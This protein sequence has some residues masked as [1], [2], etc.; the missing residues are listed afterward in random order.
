[1][2]RHAPRIARFVGIA[3]WSVLPASTL[4]QAR[5]PQSPAA[6]AAPPTA[7]SI[8]APP[9]KAAAP[10]VTA[11]DVVVLDAAGKPIEGAFVTALPSVGSFG[12]WGFADRTRS[13]LTGRE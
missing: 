13:T 10:A 3:V 2:D 9:S 8:A 12:G 1:M 11:L 5:P 4:A 7:P 6:Q